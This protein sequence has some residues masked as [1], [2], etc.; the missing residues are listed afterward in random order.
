MATS[1]VPLPCKVADIDPRIVVGQFVVTWTEVW[2]QY[3]QLIK[4]ILTTM[5]KDHMDI[6]S[7][8]LK[9]WGYIDSLRFQHENHPKSHRFRVDFLQHVENAGVMSM[10]VLHGW[11]RQLNPGVSKSQLVGKDSWDA[12]ILRQIC[13]DLL[14]SM[15]RKTECKPTVVDLEERAAQKKA[16]R[17]KKKSAK[18][19]KAAAAK[20]KRDASNSFLFQGHSSS[21]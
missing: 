5:S 14:E 8:Q 4:S 20:A 3:P 13:N 18:E 11:I 9:D 15:K 21:Q 1:N 12:Q 10:S 19:A 6:D 17:S 7:S 2:A 16:R